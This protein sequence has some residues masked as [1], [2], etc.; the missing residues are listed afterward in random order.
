M[1]PTLL[2]LLL[3]A[4]AAHAGTVTVLDAVGR[5]VAVPAEPR[6]IVSLAP[7]ITE[8]LYAL[9]LGRRVAGVTQYCDWPPEVGTKPRIG[10]VIN[11][12]LEAIVALGADLVFATADGNRPADVER[13]AALGVPVYTIDTRSI[14]EVF[15]SLV[16]I[17]E[18]TGREAAARALVAGLERRRA[19]VA[20]RLAG[21]APVPVFVAIDRAPLISA[22][23]GTFVGE[24]L[25][26]AGGRNIAGSSPIK[27]P[28][29]SLEELLAEDPQVII[30][31]ADPGPVPAAELRRSWRSLPGAARLCAVRF[32]GL[33]SVGQGSFF[34]PGPRILDSL[35][36]LA[37]IL[38]PREGAR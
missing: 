21:R 20:A 2:A 18:L 36:R 22:S 8:M 38:H 28:V 1:L 33:V 34:R 32:G 10:G 37:E 12:S 7:N 27:Y 13:L 15:A 24:M 26:L 25:T 30:D 17:G 23:A 4:V 5:T 16:T 6:R 9:D 3:P 11:P 19:A 31:A 29:F 14:S 35:E